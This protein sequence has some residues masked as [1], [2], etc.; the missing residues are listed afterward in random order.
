MCGLIALMDRS[1]PIE[2]RVVERALDALRERGPDGRQRWLSPAGDVALG[3]TR[4]AVVDIAGGAQPLWN[5]RGTVCAMLNGELYGAEALRAELRA[6]GHELRTRC[7]AELLVH[8][9]EDEGAGLTRHLR[10][11][12]AFVLY[13]SER[14]RLLGAR[15]PDGVRPLL[16]ASHGSRVMLASTVR[17][18]FAAGVPARW[19]MPALRL[20]AALQYPPPGRT[21]FAGVSPVPAGGLVMVDHAGVR[22]QRAETWPGAMGAADT[23]EH[24]EPLAGLRAALEDAVRVRIPEEVS[25][26]CALSGGL[27]SSA[28]LAFVTRITGHAP[29]AFTV[30]FEG[31][32]QSEWD[33]AVETARCF[34]AEH[35]AV[36]LDDEALAALLPQAVRDGEGSAIN[37][38]LVGKWALAR[39]V[40][41]AGHKVLLS[42]EGA[43]E[44]AFG[45][46]H[47]LVDAGFVPTAEQ[48]ASLAGAMLAPSAV[49][50]EGA[51]DAAAVPH[52][53]AAK[54]ALGAR[55]H[56]LG[57]FGDVQV[58]ARAAVDAVLRA[59]SGV[60]G[61]PHGLERS[62]AW[63]RALAFER[64]ILG[65]L[66]D[67]VEL[68]H[69]VEGRPPFLDRE[70]Q[71]AARRIAPLDFMRGGVEKQAL[72]DA[73]RRLVPDAVLARRKQPFFAAPMLLASQPGPLFE[74]CHATLTGPGAPAFVNRAAVAAQL[75]RARRASLAAR[76]DW[77]APL[78]WMLTTALLEQELLR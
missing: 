36:P 29:P 33:A 30:C 72:R 2:P 10:G 73:L 78:M 69:G 12:Y 76:R 51:R 28:V 60:D 39:A 57:D 46:A 16:L 49:R 15:D 42:G 47:F 25:Y 22:V 35:H 70:V 75:D 55:L 27:D 74:L 56:A 20:S 68:A 53:I 24:R 13:D 1:A 19:D 48:Q 41:R 61:Q 54:L 38:H 66:G 71:R 7:D 23:S 26:A 58:N 64:Y 50:A 6:R 77:E 43:D 65:T 32:V 45:Y 14:R 59:T 34:G 67:A 44:V 52:F 40:A 18:L 8:L 63:W 31:D 4:L 5:E 3:H 37:A 21:L 17:A 9:Y 62:R 11:E